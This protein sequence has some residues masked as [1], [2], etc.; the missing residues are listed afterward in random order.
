M[1]HSSTRSNMLQTQYTKSDIH[2]YTSPRTDKTRRSSLRLDARRDLDLALLPVLVGQSVPPPDAAVI[3]AVAAHA[4]DADVLDDKVPPA[5]GDPGQ[6]GLFGLLGGLL[7]LRLLLH[8][9][10]HAVSG[11]L[12]PLGGGEPGKRVALDVHHLRVRDAVVGGEEVVV[13]R[14]AGIRAREVAGLGNGDEQLLPG[15]GVDDQIVDRFVGDR[16]LALVGD[17][18]GLGEH[19][20]DGFAV[21]DGECFALRGQVS[22]GLPSGIGGNNGVIRVE[23]RL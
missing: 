20:H 5:L 7:L 3:P 8:L 22:H 4:L 11:A 2:S 21:G 18:G 14:L 15:C 19:A 13:E 6:G 10:E 17:K 12:H 9:R 16:A 23:I 1:L